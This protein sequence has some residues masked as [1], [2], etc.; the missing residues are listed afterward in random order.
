MIT[1]ANEL[2]SSN[3]SYE[4]FIEDDITTNELSEPVKI[5]LNDFK[6]LPGEYKIALSTKI[7]KWANLNG[8]TYYLACSI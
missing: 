6:I 3:N 8:A 2:E 1:I 4:L 5:E 7:S